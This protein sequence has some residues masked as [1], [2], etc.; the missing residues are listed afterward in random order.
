MLVLVLALG[1]I[2]ISL[3][4]GFPHYAEVEEVRPSGAADLTKGERI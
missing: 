1:P 4:F 3:L 2:F